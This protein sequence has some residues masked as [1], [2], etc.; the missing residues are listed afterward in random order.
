LAKETGKSVLVG[1]V[2][3]DHVTPFHT[4]A[5]GPLVLVGVAAKPTAEHVVMLKQST[6]SSRFSSLA[7]VLGLVAIDHDDPFH[8]ST[9][10]WLV[11]LALPKPTASQKAAPMH[12][13]PLSSL[14]VDPVGFGLVLIVQDDPSHSSTSVA[15]PDPVFAEP[16]AVQNELDVHETPLSVL[17]VDP[18]GL[19]LDLIVQDVPSQCSTRVIGPLPVSAEPTAVQSIALRHDTPLSGVAVEDVGVGALAT[20][21]AV[22]FHC[23]TTM[24]P[25]V[26]VPTATQNDVPTHDTPLSVGVV[27][28]DGVPVTCDHAVPFHLSM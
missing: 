13:T 12:D 27:L 16:T 15:G 24:P 9:R 14:S 5:N 23:S 11:P 20:V 8:D 2:A 26:T 22:P 28:D 6:E 10:V 19:G 18:L 7:D 25:V 3:C 4:S 1:V 17:S 21:H